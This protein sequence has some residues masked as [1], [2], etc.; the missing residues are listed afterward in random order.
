MS[1]QTRSDLT[2]HSTVFW[3]AGRAGS[4]DLGG[5]KLPESEAAKLMTD[6]VPASLHFSDISYTLGNRQILDGISGCVKP[7]QIMAIMGASGAGKSTFLDILAKK[8]KKGSIT[9]TT[10]VNGREVSDNE[11]RKVVGYVDQEDTLMPTLTAYETV[12]YSA[13]LR[14]PRE[15]S[16]E[17]KKYRTLE[18][19]QELGILGIKDMTIGSSGRLMVRVINPSTKSPTGNRSISGGEKRRVSIACELVTGPS[20]LFLDEPTS[21]LD[22]YNAYNV[23]ESLASLARD[24]NRTVV[25]TIH[26][27]RSNIVS[28]FDHLVLLARGKTVYSGEF[29][30]CHDYLEQIGQPCPPGF[31][32]ADYLSTFIIVEPP[33][34]VLT[35]SFPTQSI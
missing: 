1:N 27:P 6:H 9:G 18:T 29:S 7:G 3:Y 14:L 28:L 23:V 30:K 5:I 10:L 16:L 11:F 2:N 32:I 21:G 20:I 17:A 24:Y 31:N 25:L 34:L 19:M 8:D 35:V 22:A 12:L 4:G 13:L 26:Q 15:M 33:S